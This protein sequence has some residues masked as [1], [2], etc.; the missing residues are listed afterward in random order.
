MGFSRQEYWSGLPFPSPDYVSCVFIPS[1]C[2]RHVITNTG[3]NLQ[4]A[5]SE[6]WPDPRWQVLSEGQADMG[7]EK[8]QSD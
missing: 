6:V 1:A 8:K 4:P 3:D 2:Q 7:V 5:L